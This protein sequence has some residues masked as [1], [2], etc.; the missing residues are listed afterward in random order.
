MQTVE[1]FLIQHAGSLVL[2][3]AKLQAVNAAAQ[4]QQD[5]TLGNLYACVASGQ[6]DEAATAKLLQDPL[7][8]AYY[9]KRRNP[10]AL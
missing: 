5:A 6:V 10:D 1:H 8:A 2:Q 3:V 4:E 7:F 9:A